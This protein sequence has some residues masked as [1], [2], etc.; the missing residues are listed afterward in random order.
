MKITPEPDNTKKDYLRTKREDV[1][2]GFDNASSL[3]IVKPK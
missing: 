2:N 1:E 3:R